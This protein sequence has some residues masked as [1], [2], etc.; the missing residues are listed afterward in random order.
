[1]K[2]L[3]LLGRKSN[4]LFD[5]KVK[6]QDMEN[7]NWMLE[8][9]AIPE[10]GTASVRARP[11]VK[12]HNSSVES[13]QGYAV[14]TPKVPLLPPANGPKINSSVDGDHLPNGSIM[15]VHDIDDEDI[16]VPPP[17]PSMAPPP[18][19]QGFI[20][21]P[22]F[23]GDLATLD[24]AVLHPTSVPA[25]L[26]DPSKEEHDFS[27][28]QP[29]PMAPPKP[30]ST[31]SSG[32]GSSM[33]ISSPPSAIVPMHSKYTPPQP[34]ADNQYKSQKIPPP[35]PIRLSSASNLDS[36][37]QTPAPPSP[38]Q[39]PTASTFNPQ[40][41]AKVYT[42]PKTSILGGSGIR[43]T[44]PKQLLLLEGSGSGDS[45]PVLVNTD[46]KAFKMTASSKPVEEVRENTQVTQPS[47]IT[48][49]DIVKQVKTDSV[50]VQPEITNLPQYPSQNSPQLQKQ[51]HF[52]SVP[53]RAKSDGYKTQNQGFSPMLD[54]KL[55]NLKGS[56]TSGMQEG[57]A[58]SPLALLMAAK[59]RDKSKST[60][61]LSR[62]NSTTKS[63]NPS[64]SI[65]PSDSS[66][67]SF[68]V[69]PGSGSSSALTS[70]EG[71][72]PEN[73]TTW[74]PEKPSDPALINNQIPSAD[75][76]LNQ[77]KEAA[78]P[79]RSK[80]A[81]QEH[82]VVQT[83][84]NYH[85]AQP[86]SNKEELNMPLLPPP[87]EFNDFDN[88]MEPPPSICPP[89]PPKKKTLLPT[90]TPLVPTSVPAPYLKPTTPVAPKLPSSDNKPLATVTP[91]ATTLVPAPK[92]KHGPP[93]AP[94]LPP[95]D[96]NV[97]LRSQ[98][99]TK[100]KAAPSLSERQA[101]LQ[102]ILQKKM[103]E[104]DQKM[105]P[106]KYTESSSDD[107]DT[108]ASDEVSAWPQA[109]SQTKNYPPA[110]K[111]ATLD[112]RELQNKVAM[113]SHV[114]PPVTVPTTKPQSKYQYGVT[115]NIRPGSENP[116]TRV[117]KDDS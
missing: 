84:S 19:P 53:S 43:D 47:Q 4:S 114:S 20:P 82:S 44:K 27:F 87:P 105:A 97:N 36:P 102:S 48:Q 103:L 90:V 46:G 59:Q 100:P 106:V 107:W 10:S 61:T 58:T 9:S 56:E 60:H 22:D 13:F 31:C 88:V 86:Q 38:V 89:D 28:L 23:M 108:P 14:P 50:S 35:K 55:R 57:H 42:V 76:V 21:P 78:S 99:P 68:G 98:F 32:S 3:H 62:E 81:E 49:P 110:S 41:T 80:L 37:P 40:N 109:K 52:N 16:F 66:P 74:A 7:V 83:P 70:K 77:I 25:P 112:M 34:P 104:M 95:S 115:F 113:K 96:A 72:L 91:L 45:A 85:S 30:P 2:K 63:E 101:T 117:I 116:I 65:L 12:H 54:H 8:S 64:T 6:I 111:P 73:H 94:K 79:T 69:T 51:N 93:V 71:R 11:T 1:M 5:T 17:P 67:N 33:P 26:C 15:S 18:L 75:S 29:P 92:P 39:K 24:P